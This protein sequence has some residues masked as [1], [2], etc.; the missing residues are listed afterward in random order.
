MGRRSIL[1][2][3]DTSDESDPDET[4]LT[5]VRNAVNIVRIDWMMAVATGFASLLIYMS[6]VPDGP[7]SGDEAEFQVLSHQFGVA[8]APGHAV[9]IAIGKLATL[10][11]IGSVAYRVNLLSALSAAVAV[12]T[13]FL[14]ARAAATSRVASVIGSIILALSLTF[15]SYAVVAEVY[16][17][18]AACLA[19]VW[20]LLFGWA[21][22]GTARQ[23]FAAGVVGALGAGVD[24]GIALQAPAC[25]L[26]VWQ[27]RQSG[28]HEI[29][30]AF[31]GAATGA[32]ASAL[33][34]I[35]SVLHAPPA[36]V[37]DA[38]YRPASSQWG[39]AVDHLSSHIHQLIFIF[40]ARPWRFAMFNWDLARLR[41]NDYLTRLPVEFGGVGLLLIAMG[42][43]VLCKKEKSLALVFALAVGACW[44]FTWTYRIPDIEGFYIPGY[45]VLA[46]VAA[47]G[48]EDL[49]QWCGRI[50]SSAAIIVPVAVVSVLVVSASQRGTRVGRYR[51]S[52]A[53]IV[54]AVDQLPTQ[55]IVF[56][57]WSELYTF[58]Y[59]AQ[60]DRSRWDL[61]FIEVSPFSEHRGVV[62]RST[63]DFLSTHVDRN[64]VFFSHASDQ[65]EREGYSLH[66]SQLGPLRMFRVT[67][68]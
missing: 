68:P 17:L 57:P 37:F 49:A 47:K 66:P 21:R 25:A 29:R 40:T 58:Y 8:H 54:A 55:A 53:P 33:A 14:A 31:L 42:A 32:T 5:S 23:L 6:S 51:V 2:R 52:Y 11:P 27:R 39:L 4:L 44:L 22:T 26:F 38:I 61:R 12:A 63:F 41:A 64:P 50:A 3:Q 67:R 10:L 36:N 19:T 35:G 24:T 1:N 65:V 15:W 18:G 7:G 30:T 9:Y 43:Y 60:V 28:S 48:A 34:L 56:A 13:V 20:A 16:T 46:L 59:A 62:A 45:V